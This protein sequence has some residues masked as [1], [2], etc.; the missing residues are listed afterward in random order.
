MSD[1]E[2]KELMALIKSSNSSDNDKGFRYM[3]SAYLGMIQNVV[4]NNKG[5][6]QDGEDIFQDGMIV[7]FNQARKEDFSLNCTIKTYLYS[8]C[9]NLW[10]KKLR[11]SSRVVEL[12]DTVKQFITVEESQ[13]KTLEETEE[14]A[15]VAQYLGQLSSGCQKVLKYFYFERKKMT[16]IADLMGLANEQGAKNKKSVCMKKLKALMKDSKHFK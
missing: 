4:L 10:L 2:D 15:I 8:I 12:T 16:E 11:K 13:L 6:R 5:D 3:Y 1:L 7:L 14:K 9:R